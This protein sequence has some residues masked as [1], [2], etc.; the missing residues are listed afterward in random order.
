[1]AN[2]A[3]QAYG[4]HIHSTFPLP[5]LVETTERSADIEVGTG[6][7]MR[8]EEEQARD[9]GYSYITPEEA[10]FVQRGVGTVRIAQGRYITADPLPDADMGAIRVIIENMALGVALH[11]RGI[12]TLHASAVL[13][14]GRAVAFIGDKGWGKSTMAAHLFARGHMPLTD[15]V[16]AIDVEPQPPS[17]RPAY[18]QLKLW[19]DAA[20]SSL[21]VPPEEL[22]RTY[23]Q[24]EK[25]LYRPEGS[26]PTDPVPLQAIYVL[27]SGPELT[28][29]SLASRPAF[30]HL[31]RN[32]YTVHLLKRTGAEVRH[33]QQLTQLG[34]CVHVYHLK[35]PQDLTL[36][37]QI[38]KHVEEHA[39][40]LEFAT[41]PVQ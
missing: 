16:L 9:F 26:F 38:A 21:D 23:N 22:A 7:V 20:A 24:S 14:G 17:M 32:S 2:Y 39:Q 5:E 40:A 4:L 29:E 11:Q 30:A 1:M 15:D 36:L 34:G 28:I 13:L 35:R 10:Y 41:S 25:R 31:L 12:L 37:P 27:D 3:Y 19:P 18:P 33:L 6:S 8:V